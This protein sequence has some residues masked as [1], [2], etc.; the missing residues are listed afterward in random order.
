ME[1]S[2]NER[3]NTVAHIETPERSIVQ[4]LLDETLQLQLGERC[5]C[6]L[7]Y[8]LDTGLLL[9]TTPLS[10][11]GAEARAPGFRVKRRLT[12]EDDLLL[13]KRAKTA[14]RAKSYFKRSTD[15][16]RGQ[17][18]ILHVRL[19]YGAERLFIRYSAQIPVDL[20]RFIN[21]LQRDFRTQVDIWQLNLREQAATI[22][23]LGQCGRSTCCCSW[24]HVFSPVSLRMAKAQG[25]PLNP[26]SVNGT[27]GRLKCCLGFELDQYRDNTHADME[28]HHEDNAAEWS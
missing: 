11:M 28:E 10:Q 3:M 24:Q 27:C 6:E 12:R 23:C 5:L 2:G 22:G 16:E 20:R 26:S 25:M 17:V 7:D 8:G 19:S 4:C 9:K 1:L 21:Q 14:A 18:Q 13:G 15:R